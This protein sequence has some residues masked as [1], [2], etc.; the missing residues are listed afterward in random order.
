MEENQSGNTKTD[1]QALGSASILIY[2]WQ[3]FKLIKPVWY[4]GNC[5]TKLNILKDFDLITIFIPICAAKNKYKFSC[6]T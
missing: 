1:Q 3:E 4:I 5:Q 2:Y 6:P